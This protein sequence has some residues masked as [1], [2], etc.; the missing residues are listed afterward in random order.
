MQDWQLKPAND[1][2]LPLNQQLKSVRREGGLINA[3]THLGWYAFITF[4]LKLVHRLSVEG[5][6]HLPA[7]GSFIL[8]ANHASHLDALV[9]ASAVSWRLQSRVFPVAAGDTFFSSSL[10]GTLSALLINAL[11]MWRNRTNTH[12][13]TDLRERL[14]QEQC[15]YIVFPEGTR[16]RT[17]QTAPFRAGVGM[18]VA[19]SPVPIVPCRLIGTFEA[20]PHNRRWPKPG[21]LRLKIGPP[22]LFA[23]LSDDREGWHSV[24]KT[25]EFAVIALDHPLIEG[26]ANEP[27]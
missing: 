2:G 8:V 22:V 17:G 23:Q 19:G 26:A 20:L 5:R 18:L 1:L 14:T 21:K 9:L 25:I 11:P 6:Q 15:V 27:V 3:I 10:T 4:Y 24:A 13:R 16:S 12:G 7:S